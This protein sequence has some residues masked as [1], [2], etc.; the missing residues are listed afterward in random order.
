MV[1]NLPKIIVPVDVFNG[2]NSPISWHFG[3]APYFALVEVSEGQIK[4]ITSIKNVGEHFGGRG[5]AKELI[6]IYNPDIIIVRSIGPRALYSF[7][8]LG[9]PVLTGEVETVKEAIE[10]YFK[11]MLKPL[12]ESCREARNPYI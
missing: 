3:R 8:E 2:V 11:G 10:A 1:V 7:Q 9:I 4:S 12:T 5:K 6:L